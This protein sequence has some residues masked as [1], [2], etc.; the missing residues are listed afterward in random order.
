MLLNTDGGATYEV[1]AKE[2]SYLTFNFDTIIQMSVW[3]K[4]RKAI[5]IAIAMEYRLYRCQ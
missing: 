5:S 4:A 3:V 2:W 1:F